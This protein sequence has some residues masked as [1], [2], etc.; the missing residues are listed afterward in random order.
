[1]G[2][3]A[4][5]L[6][7]WILAIARALDSYGVDAEPLIQSV[8]IDLEAARD[9][10]VRIDVRRTSRLFRLASE[11]SKDPCFGLTV[12]RHVRPPTLH[13]VGFAIWASEDLRAALDRF[14][15]YFDILT[16]CAET[17]L[18]DHG[19]RLCFWG[20]ARPGFADMLTDQQFE[21]IIALSTLTCRLLVPGEFRPLRVG[22][23][24]PEPDD[25]S[26]YRR[27]FKCPILFDQGYAWLEVDRDTATQRLP[28]ANA[29]LAQANDLIC[30]EYLRRLQQA[31]LPKQ[32]RLLLRERLAEGEPEMDLVAR[33]LNVSV[34]TLQRKLQ[35]HG[36][37]Y[38]QLV[39]D[40]RREEALQL[41]QQSH[42]SLGEISY[43]L[44]F[45]Q[46]SSF[47]RAFKRWT[48]KTPAEWRS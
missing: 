7:G 36:R 18:D 4:T 9:P 2:E 35:D 13:A 38:K 47:C 17:G 45:S 10:N 30:V 8:G 14:N 20:R 11:A 32:V 43:R 5:T 29:E 25:I 33:S 6:G 16:T 42:I 23:T 26:S 3:S 44:G 1:M 12:A 15:R 39:D 19:D 27:M 40:V 24:R 34:R 37:S 31:D 46:S 48:G 21:A 28:T 22:L 41:I